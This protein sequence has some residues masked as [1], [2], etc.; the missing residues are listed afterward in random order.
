MTI[1]D[2]KRL[3]NETMQFDMQSLRRGLYSDH[4]FLNIVTILEALHQ[5]GY[6]F[7]GQSPRDLP[8]DPSG[9]YIGDL[10]VEAQIFNRRR[11]YAVVAGIDAA[12]GMIRHATGFFQND[13]FVETWDQLEVVAVDDGVITYYGGNPN[14]VETV[15]EIRGRYRDFAILETP[16]LGV[17]TRASRI[18]T[19]VY[20]VLRAAQGK[21]VLFFPARFDL[22][23]VQAL[24]GYAYWVAVQR[25]NYETSSKVQAAVSTDAQ[26]AWWGG[27]GGGTV[28]HAII[29]CF[30]ADTAEA[31]KAF[32]RHIPIETPRVA[33]VDFNNDTVRDSLAV[34]NAYWP[35]YRRA[36]ESGDETEQKRWTL[37]GVR[38]DTSGNMRDES[39]PE[40][41]PLGVNPL[42]VHTVR[43]A[44]DNAWA[45]WELPQN[46]V[47]TAKQ[48]CKNVQIVVSGGF[49]EEKI[50]QFEHEKVPVDVYGV[51]ST[52]LENGG[53]TSTDFTM[54]VVRLRIDGQWMTMAKKG[55][56]PCD[57]EDLRLINL[58][59][60]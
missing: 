38:L 53:S 21:Q 18:A 57:N 31:M 56:Q 49:N 51:G 24:D 30:F 7:A 15:I 28:P 60:L 42:L 50:T 59:E 6:T 29:A 48:F 32:A 37:N 33:L 52:F 14:N 9:T 46:L 45:S 3:T 13:A 34:L 27:R 1:F 25:Y 22:P 23:T 12:L 58:A 17:L 19:N 40:G 16:M 55:R 35:E 26:A 36:L 4:Y 20:Q 39:L 11:P 41:G 8:I 44:L 47:E 54:D 5:Q 43:R 10:E 2:Q